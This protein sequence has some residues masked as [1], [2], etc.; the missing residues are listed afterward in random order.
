[1]LVTEPQASNARGHLPSPHVLLSRSPGPEAPPRGAYG[2]P[3]PT[4][5][6][7][8]FACEERRQKRRT[9]S[10]WAGFS[11]F[12][13]VWLKYSAKRQSAKSA[14]Q[15]LHKLPAKVSKSRKPTRIR[16]WNSEFLLKLVGTG[17]QPGRIPFN[18]TYKRIQMADAQSGLKWVTLALYRMGNLFCFPFG[19]PKQ[20]QASGKRWL[21]A[22]RKTI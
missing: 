6:S 13:L 5:G 4:R 21:L 9:P 18:R 16:S 12:W 14:K 10:L 8:A 2:P 15:K 3:A 20:K 11:K 1:M 22:T 17:T 7:P 19:F